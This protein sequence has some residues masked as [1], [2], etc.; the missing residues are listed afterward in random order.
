MVAQYATLAALTV[1][2]MLSP[3][4]TQEFS[5]ELCH[6]GNMEGLCECQVDHPGTIQI[7]CS[8]SPGQPLT[9][10]PK[11]TEGLPY[12]VTSLIVH[13]C[14]DSVT[15]TP[16]AFEFMYNLERITFQ[17]ISH[18]ALQ[19]SSLQ[20]H[21]LSI[22]NFTLTFDSVSSLSLKQNAIQLIDDNGLR[23]KNIIIR[24]TFIT[25]LKEIAIEASLGTLRL[26]HVTLSQTPAPRAINVGAKGASVFIDFLNTSSYKLSSEWIFGNVSH[27]SIVNS[28]LTLLPNAFAGVHMKDG[29]PRS[30]L[31]LHNNTFGASEWRTANTNTPSVPS[32]P[33]RSLN[34]NLPYSGI[35]V[36]ASSNWISCKCQDIAWLLESPKT[37]LKRRIRKSLKCREGD[38]DRSLATCD[39]PSLDSLASGVAP[40]LLPAVCVGLTMLFLNY[41]C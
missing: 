11:A 29:A 32:L 23:P 14:T 5:E 9:I 39:A 30:R 17:S 31:I 20:L 13:N 38:I 37:M 3:G 35:V 6:T 19:P 18:L 41:S 2:L 24:N 7:I 40:S 21:L 4:Y 12:H 1:V 15:I 34:I 25:D 33:T 26:E 8:C 10:S 28:S 36:D 22:N 27:L 16:K